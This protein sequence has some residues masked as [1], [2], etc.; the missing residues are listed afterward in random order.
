MA[1]NIQYNRI[2]LNN[3]LDNVILETVNVDAKQEYNTF[4]PS[5]FSNLQGFYFPISLNVKQLDHI[6]AFLVD[7]GANHVRIC[8]YKQ[9]SPVLFVTDTNALCVLCPLL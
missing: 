4:L 8:L 7:K 6:L 2:H 9:K 5:L 1:A 3:D